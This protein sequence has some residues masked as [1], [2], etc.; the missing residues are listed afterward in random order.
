MIGSRSAELIEAGGFRA[1][2]TRWM[3]A[4]ETRA[5]DLTKPLAGREA[6]MDG[7]YGVG[8]QPDG[9]DVIDGGSGNDQLFGNGGN[10]KITGGSGDDIMAG[11][12]GDDIMD[13]GSGTDTV[14]IAG[15]FS[16]FTVTKAGSKNWTVHDNAGP[17]GNDTL[18]NVEVIKF[19]DRTITYNQPFSHQEH[20]QAHHV[21]IA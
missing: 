9:A 16:N 11:G 21:D 19:D 7:G 15:S 18:V 5:L 10:D 14:T 12:V 6:S 20:H 2:E 3:A 8:D 4:A 1:V 13:G 17:G